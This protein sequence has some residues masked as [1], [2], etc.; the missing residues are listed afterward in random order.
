MKTT[1]GYN[2]LKAKIIALEKEL[3]GHKSME[4]DLQLRSREITLL[5]E[6]GKQVSS[7]LFLDQVVQSALDG[8]FQVLRPDLTIIFLKE[9]DRLMVHGQKSSDPTF[10]H[11]VTNEHKAGQCLCGI[12]VTEAKAIYAVDINRDPRCTWN[13]CK[14]AGFTSF[15]ALPLFARNTIIGVMGLAS[16]TE[17]D[18]SRQ[19]IFLEAVTSEISIGLQNAIFYKQIKDYSNSL[20]KEAARRAAA[21]SALKE[22]EKQYRRLTNNI[23]ETIW[24]IDLN[25]LRFTYVSPSLDHISGFSDQEIK[26]SRLEEFFPPASLKLITNA[27]SEEMIADKSGLAKPRLLE[28][29]HFHK[30]GSTFW[31]E[32]SAR[33]VRD[34]E[35]HPYAIVG[36]TRDITERKQIEAALQKSEA[37]YRL[38]ADNVTDNIWVFDLV[39]LRFTYVSPS[40]IGITGFT[41]EEAT[42]FQLEDALTPPSLEI[43]NKILEE[44]LATAIQ[45]FDPARSRTLELEMYHK[46]GA[47]VWTEVSVQ[48]TYDQKNQPTA[49]LGVT[50]DISERKRLQSKLFKSQKMESLGLLAGGVAHDLNNVLSGIVSYPELILID[51]PEDSKLRKPL[52]TMMESGLR[53]VAIVQDLLTVARG[54][55]T[56]KESLK[57]NDLVGDYLDSPEFKKLKQFYPMVMVKTH[58]AADLLNISAS[59]VH[60]RK[61]VMNLVAN[62]AEAIQEMGNVTISTVNRYVDKPLKGYDEVST[63]EYAVLSISDNGSGISSDDL[64]RIFEPFYTKKVMGRSGTG[65]GLAVVWNVVQD[66]KGYIDVKTDENGT[67]FEV[68]F[69]ITRDEIWEKDKPL[70]INSYKGNGETIL[71]V[72]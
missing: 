13:E 57:I 48:F 52:K 45:N 42:G 1:P 5:N 60:I 39:T 34:T 28:L 29:E 41:S 11:T 64:E 37:R 22:S 68:Y 46:S 27:L 54:V 21:E 20:E 9:G 31:A 8:I 47:T 17:R 71:V 4:A 69:P 67:T 19:S 33:F 32:I 10:Q 62:A 23:S 66:H 26:N 70:S 55:A 2:D 58:L 38:L 56:T 6:I 14:K 25:T 59:Y 63:G 53:A 36:V 51:L 49:I 72:H 44:E 50:R 43:A 24:E 15:A 35:G 3:S 12:A 7:S 65:L 40:V 61:V 30:N 16:A 18:F